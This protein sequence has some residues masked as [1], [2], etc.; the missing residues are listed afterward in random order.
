MKVFLTIWI[1]VERYWNRTLIVTLIESPIYIYILMYTTYQLGNSTIRG[2]REG[3]TTAA[4]RSVV[5]T[6]RCCS[7]SGSEEFSMWR[8]ERG[9]IITRARLFPSLTKEYRATGT[10]WKFTKVCSLPYL[11]LISY[12]EVM[13]VIWQLM[14]C[15][16]DHPCLRSGNQMLEMDSLD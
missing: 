13:S 3:I 12:W 6:R 11:F 5:W 1:H 16:S 8:L 10:T 15:S 14:S 4:N 7:G 2:A 9:G